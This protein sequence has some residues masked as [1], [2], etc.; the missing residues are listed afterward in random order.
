ML[1]LQYLNKLAGAIVQQLQRGDDE[2]AVADYPLI[3]E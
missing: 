3:L 2:E 1:D